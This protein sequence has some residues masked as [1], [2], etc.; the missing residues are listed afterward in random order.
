MIV[1]ELLMPVPKTSGFL[2]NCGVN[3]ALHLIISN[4][5]KLAK[6]P[7]TPEIPDLV[8]AQYQELLN[9]FEQRYKTNVTY[10]SLVAYLESLKNNTAQQIIMGPVLRDYMKKNGAAEDLTSIQNNGRYQMLTVKEVSDYAYAPLGISIYATEPAKIPEALRAAHEIASINYH[11][12]NHHFQSETPGV[13]IEEIIEDHEQLH[14]HNPE[15]YALTSLMGED[16]LATESCL[17]GM[18]QVVQSGLK[19]LNSLLPEQAS[20]NYAK[21][22]TSFKKLYQEYAQSQGFFAPKE[23]PEEQIKE[24]ALGEKVAFKSPEDQVEYDEKLATELQKQEFDKI[25]D[26]TELDA[27]E[28]TESD[29]EIARLLQEEGYSKF[30]M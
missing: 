4:F 29:E 11:L 16:Q 25:Q 14:D 12:E 18:C 10:S 6:N 26:E 5:K 3:G 21:T 27:T 13:G 24:Y 22:M 17:E 2:N 15:L 23:V 8:K 20:P 1:L 19:T 7:Q 30:S 28:Q 9:S